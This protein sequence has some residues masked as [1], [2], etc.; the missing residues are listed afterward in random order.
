MEL[1]SLNDEMRRAS[2]GYEYKLL[3]SIYNNWSYDLHAHGNTIENKKLETIGIYG[4]VLWYFENKCP[5]PVDYNFNN[6]EKF[7]D[8][9]ESITY[10]D[11]INILQI[12]RF[13]NIDIN[14][15]ELLNFNNKC[16]YKYNFLISYE[17]KTKKNMKKYYLKPFGY[18]LIDTISKSK[19]NDIIK[20]CYKYIKEKSWFEKETIFNTFIHKTPIIKTWVI[21]FQKFKVI[22]EKM[23]ILK[24]KDIFIIDR[25]VELVQQLIYSYCIY[26]I[27]NFMINSEDTINI[28]HSIIKCLEN[29]KLLDAFE[30][31]DNCIHLINIT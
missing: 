7:I 11:F 23:T 5:L 15:I 9:I 29:E 2:L 31:F 25:F 28:K 3:R 1:L 21:I 19:F 4:L 10:Y 12:I 13:L 16:K 27:N 6:L 24:H 22:V 14:E 17:K 26:Y 18:F 8:N 30:T 20:Q